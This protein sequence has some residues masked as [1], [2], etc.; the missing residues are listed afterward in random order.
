M[1]KRIDEAPCGIITITPQ[2]NIHYINRTFADM[3]QVDPKSVLGLHIE[4]FMSVSN[5]LL[6][7]T[8]FYPYI[9][10][11]GVVE[12]LLMTF[13]AKDGSAVPVS[14]S[15]KMHQLQNEVVIDCSCNSMK[16]RFN[17]EQELRDIRAQLEDTLKEKDRA[18]E[19]LKVLNEEV[20]RLARTDELTGLA[21]RRYANQWMDRQ[22][23]SLLVGEDFSVVILDIDHFKQINDAYG[24]AI[25]DL[26]LKTMAQTLEEMIP[27]DALVGRYGGE[28]FIVIL[29]RASANVTRQIGEQ[30][31]YAVREMKPVPKSITI[32]LG[33][34][35]LTAID[36]RDSLLT[37][38]D[39]ALYYAKMSGRDRFI[40][41]HEVPQTFELKG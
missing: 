26:V 34:A 16:K 4:T 13:Q 28:E 18:Y 2:G 32:S 35:Q 21:N 20:Q 24:H 29:P 39:R 22:L 9:T 5:R 10:M 33:S 7:H 1:R 19:E 3:L 11:Y 8:Y 27:E 38:A 17:Y 41:D 31:R 12:E 14:M 15:G 37:R 25:G 30:L 40:M 23:A 6:F 36:S